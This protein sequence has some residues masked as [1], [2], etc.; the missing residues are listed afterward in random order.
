MK[1]PEAVEWLGTVF[2]AAPD[3]LSRGER[4]IV[5]AIA[6]VVAL[7]RLP[8]VARSPWDWDE[9]L[10]SLGVRQFDVTRHHPHPPGFPLFVGAGKLLHLTGLDEFRAL[11]LLGLLGAMLLFPALFFFFREARASYGGALGAALL[12]VFSPNVWFFGG[13]AFS[14]VPSLLLATLTLA[15]LLRSVR[16]P[17]LFP[18]AAAL[19]AFAAAIRPQNLLVALIPSIAAMVILLRPR[20]DPHRAVLARPRLVTSGLLLAIL[21]LLAFYGAAAMASGGWPA[22]HAAVVAH[23]DYIRSADSFLSP[24]RPSLWRVSDDF[25][26]RPYRQPVLNI[27]LAVLGLVG[28]LA[29]IRGRERIAV[30]VSAAAFLPVAVVS[31]LLLDFHSVSRFS[32]A[33]TPL[34]ALLATTGIEALS[35]AIARRMAGRV[36]APGGWRDKA[37]SQAA[38]TVVISV[39]VLGGMIAWTLPA[40]ATA[41]STI[42]PPVAAVRWAGRQIDLRHATLSVAPDM[43]AFVQYLLPRFEFVPEKA[44]APR[45]TSRPGWFLTDV[46]PKSAAIHFG[47]AKN[48]LWNIARRRY[49]DVWLVP[50]RESVVFGSGW[51]PEEGSGTDSP[52]R[53]MS[54][55]SRLQLPPFPGGATLFL[56]VATPGGLLASVT[57]SAGGAAIERFEATPAGVEITHRFEAAE[58]AAPLTI[59]MQVDRTVR[60]SSVGASGDQ[61]ELGLRLGDLNWR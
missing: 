52:Y 54:G 8:A 56:S 34:P 18:A 13:T 19:A 43:S 42:A 30:A 46:E 45:W 53:W 5:R 59:T 27:V 48:A 50:V 36:S 41:R 39:I 44:P 14:D 33:W 24:A 21:L 61:R 55:T 10:F 25:F 16:H 32:I 58:T 15:V 31:W 28:L 35:A 40:L 12:V 29:S 49:F 4:A 9:M 17:S 7:S 47:R 3:P 1:P 57:I 11:Q 2:G 60:P 23:G 20:M 38:I 26:V 51:F 6:V 22:Y 37:G